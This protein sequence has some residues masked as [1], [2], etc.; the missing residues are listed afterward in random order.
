MTYSKS[1]NRERRLGLRGGGAAAPLVLFT[2]P[3]Q[4][5]QKKKREKG[6]VRF[7]EVRV[8]NKAEI[9]SVF[10]SFCCVRVQVFLGVFVLFLFCFL[11]SR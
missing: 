8:N 5:S 1:S 6:G 11:F 3:G 7:V 10:S 2:R 4:C 9:T